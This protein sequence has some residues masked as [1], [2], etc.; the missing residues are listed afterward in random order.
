ME[1]YIESILLQ[2]ILLHGICYISAL[3]FINRFINKKDMMIYIILISL[4]SFNIYLNFPSIM[5][6]LYIFI[7]HLFFYKKE[8]F[9]FYFSYMIAYHFFILILLKMNTYSTYQCG[10]L[11]IYQMNDWLKNSI[12]LFI[13]V[14]LYLIH[15]FLL[16]R[17]LAL[18]QLFYPIEFTYQEKK[19]CLT[20]YLDTGNLATYKGVPIIFIKAGLLAVESEEVMTINGINANSTMKRILVYDIKIDNT[21]YKKMYL[22]ESQNLDLPADCLLNVALLYKG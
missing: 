15:A 16:K 10:L 13:I 6:Y 8:V 12:L 20:G 11:I 14:G 2:Q 3:I 9:F 4:I 17:N 7:I 22:V 1:V 5:I 19:Y 21:Y 18:K